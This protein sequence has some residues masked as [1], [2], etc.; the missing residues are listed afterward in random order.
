MIEYS[1]GKI[2][3]KEA[4]AIE[5]AD[6]NAYDFFDALGS[7]SFIKVEE[8]SLKLGDYFHIDYAWAFSQFADSL[9]ALT[10]SQ[11]K[12]RQ[13]SSCVARVNDLKSKIPPRQAPV[14]EMEIALSQPRIDAIAAFQKPG[15]PPFFENSGKTHKIKDKA[16]GVETA[17]PLA[18]LKLDLDRYFTDARYEDAFNFFCDNLKKYSAELMKNPQ[19]MD[20]D[21]RSL[22]FMAGFPTITFDL[23]MSQEQIKILK[24]FDT[25]NDLKTEG[26]APFGGYPVLRFEFDLKNLYSNSF[27]RD[28]LGKYA[29]KVVAYYDNDMVENNYSVEKMDPNVRNLYS[30]HASLLAYARILTVRNPEAVGDYGAYFV[31]PTLKK[32]QS[33]GTLKFEL[34]LGDQRIGAIKG[35]DPKGEFV[36]VTDKKVEP[37]TV[38]GVHLDLRKLADN[39]E[40]YRNRFIPFISNVVAQY[41]EIIATAIRDGVKKSIDEFDADIREFYFFLRNLKKYAGGV[42]YNRSHSHTAGADRWPVNP[43]EEPPPTLAKPQ[44]D[45]LPPTVGA[46]PTAVVGAPKSKEEFDE[47]LKK[48]AEDGDLNWAKHLLSQA[49]QLSQEFPGWFGSLGATDAKLKDRAAQMWQLRLEQRGISALKKLI[50]QAEEAP[51]HTFNTRWLPFNWLSNDKDNRSDFIASCKTEQIDLAKLVDAL[52]KYRK[53]LAERISAPEAGP[54]TALTPIFEV[55]GATVEKYDPR[56][57]SGKLVVFYTEVQGVEG[58]EFSGGKKPGTDQHTLKPAITEMV[59][60]KPAL[61]VTFKKILQEKVFTLGRV[62]QPD[63]PLARI[64]VYIEAVGRKKV[65]KAEVVPPI[66]DYFKKINLEWFKPPLEFEELTEAVDALREDLGRKIEDNS[67]F[68]I[69][70]G[71][72]FTADKYREGI[73]ILYANNQIGQLNDLFL[74]LE[75]AYEMRRANRAAAKEALE[76][77]RQRG[78]S[79]VE[80]DLVPPGADVLSTPPEQPAPKLEPSPSKPSPVPPLPPAPPIT[81]LDEMAPDARAAAPAPTPTPSSTPGTVE[82]RGIEDKGAARTGPLGTTGGV[83]PRTALANLYAGAPAVPKIN[84][85]EREENPADLRGKKLYIKL[86]ELAITTNGTATMRKLFEDILDKEAGNLDLSTYHLAVASFYTD[87]FVGAAK[88]VGYKDVSDLNKLSIEINL[89]VSKKLSELAHEMQRNRDHTETKKWLRLMKVI[90]NT[91]FFDNESKGP[92]LPP[93]SL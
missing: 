68:V 61:T 19:Q 14:L 76:K 45:E 31:P 73:R 46:T 34:P 48:I 49:L 80:R 66:E 17:Y 13:L 47:A 3:E 26:L 12:S 33:E 28:S 1:C 72:S 62:G 11:K 84:F 88:K 81:R 9:S 44:D 24:G 90:N 79:D 69:T 5:A 86:L 89:L 25:S 77:L 21:V 18:R 85:P 91:V 64:R 36:F 41:D 32:Y 29:Q 4:D 63:E 56:A 82:R 53:K 30:L 87:V 50:Q 27:Y 40:D 10:A 8:E 23:P 60:G 35:G 58:M 38:A 74:I 52:K 92:L 93:V 39:T 59:G 15:E 42:D 16:T 2:P 7:N 83:T 65:A 70:E 43:R 20:P 71:D 75:K 67:L 6:W 57:G 22:Y 51:A 78:K 37:Y 55:T 54:A